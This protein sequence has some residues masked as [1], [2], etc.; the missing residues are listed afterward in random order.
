MA[1]TVTFYKASLILYDKNFSI[2]ASG[3]I[4]ILHQ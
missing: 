1:C 3:N 4:P 2:I